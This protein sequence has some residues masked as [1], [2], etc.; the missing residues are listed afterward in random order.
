MSSSS[1]RRVPI[2]EIGA[3]FSDEWPEYASALPPEEYDEAFLLGLL[4]DERFFDAPEGSALVWVPM[5]AWRA[6]A[7]MRSLEVIDPVLRLAGSSFY[8]DAYRDFPRISALLGERAI[9]P[10]TAILGDRA[11]PETDRKLAADG[12]GAIARDSSGPQRARIVDALMSQIRR[13]PC[14]GGVNAIA[15]EALMVMEERSVGPELLRMRDEGRLDLGLGLSQQLTEFF[16][17]GPG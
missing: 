6:L 11:R 13:D 12:L 17:E 10:L 5:H 8:T 3:D 14:D 1:G 4:N 2:R 7:Q 15:A 9:E 16:G